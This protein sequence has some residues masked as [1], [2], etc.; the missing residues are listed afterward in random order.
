MISRLQ[1]AA[2]LAAAAGG[3]YVASET[4]WGQDAMGVIGGASTVSYQGEGAI[5]V[6]GAAH[7]HHEVEGLRNV[8]SQRY[9]FDEDMARKLG[10]IPA[11]PAAVPQL[12][13]VGVTDL[14]EVIRFD[15]TPQWVIGRF[16]R[17]STVLADLNLE[18]LRVP[19]VTGTRADDLAGTLTYYFDQKST[20]QRVT[21]HGFTGDPNKLVYAATSHYGLAA[22]P[23]LEA[24]VYTKRWNGKP[25]H[26]L[27]LTHAPVVYSD[28]VHQ[29]YTVFMEL[30]QPS[31]HY[32]ISAE[33]KRI[34]DADRHSGRW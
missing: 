6:T 19:V 7:A 26:F 28:A 25:V 15:I 27:R 9:R 10:A 29:K 5:S 17:V 16:A 34:V 21:F 33:A 2:L 4:Q 32:G 11:D 24:G 18:G 20:L 31:L 23:T 13:M 12:A 22:E 30:N 8:N 3:P 14:R 1:T